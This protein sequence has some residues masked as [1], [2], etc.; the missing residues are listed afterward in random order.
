MRC[1]KCDRE[2]NLKIERQVDE[3]CLNCFSKS[4]TK[5]QIHLTKILTN[6]INRLKL[7]EEMKTKNGIK[8]DFDSIIWNNA[9][10]SCID[11]IN[12]LIGLE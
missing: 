3:L 6:H 8:K 1:K 4:I 11:S 12:M 10:S 5:E 2:I 9:I 7:P